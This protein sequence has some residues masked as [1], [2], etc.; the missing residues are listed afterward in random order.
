MVNAAI[1]IETSS[2][3]ALFAGWP[4]RLPSAVLIPAAQQLVRAAELLRRFVTV[5]GC[6][7]L[8]CTGRPFTEHR[9]FPVISSSPALCSSSLSSRVTDRSS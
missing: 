2:P 9:K 4:D 1:R 6:A 8:T 5:R 3:G 7:E